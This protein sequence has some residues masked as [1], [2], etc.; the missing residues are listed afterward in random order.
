MT[1]TPAMTPMNSAPTAGSATVL[2]AA[3]TTGQRS[4]WA[5]TGYLV[6]S[7]PPTRN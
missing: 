5:R 1:I 4:A 3:I 2:G 6:E 7:R